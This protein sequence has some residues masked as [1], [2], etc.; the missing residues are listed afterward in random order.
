[1]EKITH[2]QPHVLSSHSTL[3]AA[4][5]SDGGRRYFGRCGGCAPCPPRSKFCHLFA[6]TVVRAAWVFVASSVRV[7]TVCVFSVCL[8]VCVCVGFGVSFE[9]SNPRRG[10]QPPSREF[11]ECVQCTF[12]VP[13]F[14]FCCVS[15][16][17][18]L[19][20]FLTTIWDWETIP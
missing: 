3:T 14:M 7:S 4:A 15:V 11:L 9:T 17:L 16:L 19:A 1:M 12:C 20:G 6:A 18:C 10:N 5:L 8:C 2:A 13:F